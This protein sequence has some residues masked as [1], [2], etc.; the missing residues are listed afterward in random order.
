M[1]DSEVAGPSQAN[2]PAPP[3]GPSRRPAPVPS[4][5]HAHPYVHQAER[6]HRSGGGG[7]LRAGVFGANDGLVSNFSLVMGVSGAGTDER[8]ILLAGIAGLLAGAFSMAAGEYVSVKAQREL[9][10]RQLEIERLEIHENPV[11]E[12][13]ELVQIYQ[14]KGLP[15]QD[16][17][18]L[19]SAVMANPQT[20]LDTHAREELGLNPADLGSPWRAAGSSFLFFAI[21]ALIPVLP[22][23]L[24]PL[25]TAFYLSAFLSALTLF[26][27]G[28]VLSRITGRHLLWSGGRMLLIG[29]AAAVTTYL[30]GKLIGV[31]VS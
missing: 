8:F 19:A 2:A 22:F 27:I 6:W 25:P 4:V 17:H 21:G 24:L 7:A 12:H 29:G 30:V 1:S 11:G 20:A 10:E 13:R 14:G 5:Q 15:R 9:F 23:L 26:A 31:S 16:A 28:A 18:T 3:A